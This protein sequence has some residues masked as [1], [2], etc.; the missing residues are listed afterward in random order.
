[1]QV[2]DFERYIPFT[3]DDN[4]T[5]LSRKSTLKKSES[6]KILHWIQ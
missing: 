2:T 4:R 6:L 1:M 3:K 5:I